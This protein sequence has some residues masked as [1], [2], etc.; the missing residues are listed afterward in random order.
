MNNIIKYN[1]S[2][3]N[4]AIISCE[5]CN[6]W[7]YC[8]KYDEQF[9]IVPSFRNLILKHLNTINNIVN[10]NISNSD[11]FTSSSSKTCFLNTSE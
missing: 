8:Q 2:F 5:E 3:E 6:K 9:H 7:C 11:I 1:G 10:N 4:D